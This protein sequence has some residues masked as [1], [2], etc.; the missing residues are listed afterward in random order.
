MI[1]STENDS[2]MSAKWNIDE[3]GVAAEKDLFAPI[4]A[5]GYSGDTDLIA[6]GP[7]TA[8]WLYEVY[9]SKA[10]YTIDVHKNQLKVAESDG[11][12]S[13]T[14]ESAHTVETSVTLVGVS[15]DS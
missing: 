6:T 11:S 14:N 10:F 3:N 9:A 7:Y 2:L 12:F 5:P 15:S 13:V 4:R 8:K 1:I